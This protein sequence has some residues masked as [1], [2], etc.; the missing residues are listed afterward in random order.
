[1]NQGDS[2]IPLPKVPLISLPIDAVEA[3]D[4]ENAEK[5]QYTVNDL[6]QMLYDEIKHFRFKN[7]KPAGVSTSKTENDS[8]NILS[9]GISPDSLFRGN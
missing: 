4:Y 8:L 9:T 5:A 7:D 3:F 1:M 2:I 6:K